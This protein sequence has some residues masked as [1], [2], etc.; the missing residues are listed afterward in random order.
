MN[1]VARLAFLGQ[2]AEI[3]FCFKLVGVNKTLA[4][5]R[6]KNYFQK[7]T[8]SFFRQNFC[9]IFVINAAGKISEMRESKYFFA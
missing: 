7:I 5:L 9:K 8:I 4:F 1:K 6:Q 3:W 2:I